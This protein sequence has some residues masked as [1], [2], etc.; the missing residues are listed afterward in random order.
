MK[1]K[2]CGEI[3]KGADITDLLPKE[4]KGQEDSV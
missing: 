1:P 3:R 2:I 4:P